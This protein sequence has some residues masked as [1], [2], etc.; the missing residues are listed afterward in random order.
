MPLDFASAARL[1]MGSEEELAAALRIPIADLRDARTNP[2]RA[3]P[4]LLHRMGALLE[5]RGRGMI[6][7]GEMLREDNPE[8]RG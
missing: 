3:A 5:E 2:Q 7:V 8:R 4:D 1:F 6:R